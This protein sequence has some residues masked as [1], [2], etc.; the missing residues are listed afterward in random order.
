MRRQL[1]VVVG[2]LGLA[3]GGETFAGGTAVPEGVRF[4]SR[5]AGEVIVAVTIADR[6]PFRFLLDTGSTHSAV[7][8]ALAA[9]LD[10]RPVAQ[11]VMT[12]SSGSVGCLVVQVSDIAIGPARVDRLDATAL[13]LGA[14][15]A[16]GERI[17]GI[18]GQDFLS[19]FNFTVDYERSRLFWNDEAPTDPGTRLTLTASAGRFFVTLP[20]HSDTEANP[21]RLVPDSGADAVILFGNQSARQLQLID[22][23]H[24]MRLDSLAGAVTIRPAVIETLQV[25]AATLRH[26]RAAIIA[27]KTPGEDGDGLLPLHVFASVSFNNRDGYMVVRPR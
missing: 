2:F 19:R 14:A 7:T 16:L 22:E 18:I 5:R 12:T 24:A 17:D 8:E 27:V 21:L 3:A 10:A 4:T 6:G 1:V 11:T 25:G 23:P 20:Q 13:P 9:A 26:Q 15:A